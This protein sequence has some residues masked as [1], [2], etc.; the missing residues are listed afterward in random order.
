MIW[1][2]SKSVGFLNSNKKPLVNIE[3]IYIFKKKQGT[4]NPQKIKGKPY[5]KTNTGNN[6]NDSCAYGKIDRSNHLEGEEHRR[7][8]LGDRYPLVY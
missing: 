5:N 2:K 4:Y 7:I 6:N 3:N 8:N 1:E